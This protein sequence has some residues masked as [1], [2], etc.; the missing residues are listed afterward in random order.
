MEG[1]TKGIAK[2]IGIDFRLDRIGAIVER[3]IA[4]SGAV[5]INAQDFS[6]QISEVLRDKGADIGK[7]WRGVI[8]V[9]HKEF[10]ILAE[11]QGAVQMV[12]KV[13]GNREENRFAVGQRDIGV[14]R[15]SCKTGEPGDFG[16]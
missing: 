5:L 15:I 10:A 12:S 16:A 1:E 8:S 7:T 14:F 9:P 4:R 11:P 3:I 2:S 6:T 13:I